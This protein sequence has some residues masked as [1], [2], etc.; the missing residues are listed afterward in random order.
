[1]R[2]FLIGEVFIG[3]RFGRRN[4]RGENRFERVRSPFDK[5]AAHRR[6]RDTYA[7]EAIAAQR[8]FR[9]I[10]AHSRDIRVGIISIYPSI[11]SPAAP[12]RDTRRQ[13]ESTGKDVCRGIC[14]RKD[15]SLCNPV[16]LLVAFTCHALLRRFPARTRHK[17]CL[18]LRFVVSSLDLV[19]RSLLSFF[20]PLFSTLHRV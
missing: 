1:M 11:V 20:L 15:E 8:N 18:A 12:R 14:A 2:G 6:T 3:R 10:S 17:I 4:D 13:R 5:R 9:A 16:V 7:R 19:R